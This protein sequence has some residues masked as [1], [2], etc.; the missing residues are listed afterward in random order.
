MASPKNSPSYEEDELNNDALTQFQLECE[1]LLSER[2]A[3]AGSSISNRSLGFGSLPL[4][5]PLPSWSGP[6]KK[7][8]YIRGTIKDTDITFWIHQ[9]WAQ[10][11]S[12]HGSFEFLGYGA[13]EEFVDAVLE[14]IQKGPRKRGWLWK[15]LDIG[16]E[17]IL[18]F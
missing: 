1:R 13:V 9:D 5:C 17:C 18:S 16:P 7:R 2:V 8:I 6:G 10:F 15:L 3:Q 14:T 11:E 12:S 4:P